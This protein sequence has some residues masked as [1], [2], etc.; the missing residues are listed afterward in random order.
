MHRPSGSFRSRSRRRA[1]LALALALLTACPH[2]RPKPAPT[3]SSPS[4][5]A[6]AS[7]RGGELV[8]AYPHE[9]ATLNPF[10]A[11]GDAP[12]TRD[13]VRSLMPSLYVVEPGGKRV[14]SLLDGEPE[15]VDTQE[16][17][18]PNR[19]IVRMTLR[20]DAVWSDG[21]PITA[22]DV[23]F[24]WQTIMN[25][26]WHGVAR[27]GYDRIAKVI[28]DGPKVASLVFYGRP[29]GRWQD[30]FS[31]GLGVLPKHVLIGKP[32]DTALATSWPVSGGPFVL[33]SWTPGLQIVLQRNPRA[34]EKV[35]SLDRS[36]VEFVPDVVTAFQL[37]ER[38][39]VDALV[40]YPGVEMQRR[41][42]LV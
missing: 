5:T 26:R 4:A 40:P 17:G 25:K 8:V 11:G 36:R 42:A 13:L 30:L 38:G 37:L 12:A 19:S 23:R 24:T 3:G 31:A 32:F 20:S 15:Q 27:E 21:V 1:G 10:L 41:G 16:E 14:P 2:T 33:K 18:S 29:F 7:P 35:P 9:P 6:A 39:Q 22:E 28:V 34:W